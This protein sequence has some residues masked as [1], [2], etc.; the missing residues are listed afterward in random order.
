MSITELT[1]LAQELY[2]KIDFEIN[3]ASGDS[4]APTFRG[5]NLRVD[6]EDKF[7]AYRLLEL[8]KN[9]IAR[10]VTKYIAANYPSYSFDIDAC[11][12]DVKHYIDAFKYDLLYPGNYRTLMAGT[13]YGN[14]ARTNG[15]VLE[16]MFLFRDA[17]GLRNMTVSGLSGTLG[18]ANAYGTKR[19]TAGA[20][21]SLDPG[22]GPD[23]TRTWIQ[24]RSPYVQGVTTF[25]T[26][27]V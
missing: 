17:T 2:D 7:K 6:D 10:D 15:S 13:Y 21:A 22:W 16:N 1:E 5:N 23:D 27:C 3:G 4:T 8:N 25:G 9:F 20:Y 24:T 19:P 12:K 11:E 14:S 18:S 26:G